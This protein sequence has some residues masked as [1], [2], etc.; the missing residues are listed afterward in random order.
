VLAENH[1]NVPGLAI[2]FA[3]PDSPALSPE[4]K[5]ALSLLPYQPAA[6]AAFGAWDTPLPTPQGQLENAVPFD[7]NGLA[8]NP[9]TDL[10]G[11]LLGLQP[12]PH[13]TRC[14]SACVVIYASGRL[15]F[16]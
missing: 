7:K 8:R 1:I 10:P 2:T 16:A 13:Y 9:A 14:L 11:E 5:S 6:E 4:S 15:R 3:D 12:A